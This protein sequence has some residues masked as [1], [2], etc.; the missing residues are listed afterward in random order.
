MARE[1]KIAT[2][3]AE[4]MVNLFKPGKPELRT[5]Q[6]TVGFGTKPK[7]SRGVADRIAAVIKQV[8][9]DI[10]GICEGPPLKS[11]MERF[12]K[13]RLGDD[14]TVYSMEDGSAKRSRPASQAPE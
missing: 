4:W 2:F 9:A 13:D 11:Q 14:Y 10:I 3:N 12:V 1:I 6:N 5:Q 7:N 8:D